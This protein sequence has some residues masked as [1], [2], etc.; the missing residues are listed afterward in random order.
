MFRLIRLSA[1]GIR[2]I[3]ASLRKPQT[4]VNIYQKCP[5][6]WFKADTMTPTHNFFLFSERNTK[7]AASF[8]FD[9]RKC[10]DSSLYVKQRPHILSSLIKREWIL[11]AMVPLLSKEAKGFLFRL[12]ADLRIISACVSSSLH[13][14]TL[15][16][17][18][19]SRYFF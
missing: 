11:K 4:A 18:Q 10:V 8:V 19:C 3:Y 5:N 9:A 2:D 17:L 16:H 14:F 12:T 13:V 6:S 15:L 1:H 7:N